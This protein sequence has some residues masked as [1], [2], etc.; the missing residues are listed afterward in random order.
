MSTRELG[1]YLKDHHAGSEGALAI[2]D[3]IEEVHGGDAAGEMTRLLRP[4]FIAEQKQITTLLDMLDQPPSLPRRAFGWLSEKGLELK[5]K[6]DD[7]ADGPLHLL[8][9]TEMLALGVHGKMSLWK[10]LDAN[11][12]LVPALATVDFQTLIRQAEAQ[13]ALI[14]TVRMSAARMA[15]VK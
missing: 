13:R 1:T 15:I 9:S 12:E 11:K 5:L 8:E 3:H 4:E 10:A 6:V 14:E 2:L 7:A